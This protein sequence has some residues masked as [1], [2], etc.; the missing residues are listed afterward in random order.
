[1][2]IT[3]SIELKVYSDAA[4]TE[5]PQQIVTWFKRALDD[6]TA[7]AQQSTTVSIAASGTQAFNLNGLTSIDRFFLYSDTANVTLTINGS[8]TP[9]TLKYG[10]PGFIPITVTSMSITNTSSTLA[11]NV[12]FIP[13]TG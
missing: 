5:F 9:L 10:V 2:F 11:T 1:M 6:S 3:G 13:I 7:V 8:A 12:T 4:Q